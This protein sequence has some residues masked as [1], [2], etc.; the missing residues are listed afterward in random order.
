MYVVDQ[1]STLSA[2]LEIVKHWL[3]ESALSWPQRLLYTV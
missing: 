3:P 2:R 1:A